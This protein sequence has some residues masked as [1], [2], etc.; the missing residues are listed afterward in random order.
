MSK[1]RFIWD[2]W[3]TKHTRSHVPKFQRV[4]IY[5][6]DDVLMRLKFLAGVKV[7]AN[8]VSNTWINALFVQGRLW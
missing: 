2:H 5:V 7:T 4:V 6:M 3:W 8:S 1:V